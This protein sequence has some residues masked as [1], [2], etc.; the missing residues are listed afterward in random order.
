M[1]RRRLE[2]YDQACSVDSSTQGCAGPPEACRRAMLEIL[3]T[4]LRTNC[5]CEGST[6]DFRELYDCIGWHRLL[7]VNPC[8]GKLKNG[9]L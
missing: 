9:F 4:E 3:G 6:A 2:R 5:G 7:W 8:V 1:K